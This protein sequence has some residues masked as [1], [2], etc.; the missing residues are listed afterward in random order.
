MTWKKWFFY[1]DQRYALKGSGGTGSIN[2]ASN[3]GAGDGVFKQ[4]ALDDLE[5]KTLTAGANITLTDSANEIEIS[6]TGGGGGAVDSVNGQTGVVVLDA[7]DIS[8]AA[9][10]NKFATAAELA[11]IALNTADRHVAVSVT[12]SPEIDFT[13][14][15]QDITASIVAGSLN[16]SKFDVSVNASLDLADTAL[17]DVVNDTT[18]TL[19]GNLDGGGFNVSSV[20]TINIAGRS[21][22]Y[23]AI[24]NESLV[25]ADTD[26]TYD[27]T[28]VIIPEAFYWGGTHTLTGNGLGILTGALFRA[29]GTI[30]NENGTA[31]TLGPYYTVVGQNTYQAD[32]AAVTQ[33][34]NFNLYSLPTFSGINGGAFTC[35][36]MT[37]F[38]S[39]LY[40]N[41]GATITADYSFKANTPLGTGGTITG[42]A[43]F[44]DS[45]F[46][47]ATNNTA[48]LT[49]TST[50]PSGNWNVYQANGRLNR[51]NGGHIRRTRTVSATTTVSAADDVIHIVGAVAAVT[52]T[53]PAITAALL[54]RVIT[55]KNLSGFNVTVQSAGAN[56]I[57]LLATSVVFGF[58]EAYT[59]QVQSA[60]NWSVIGRVQ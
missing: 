55:F 39:S 54:G 40:I 36:D 13:L 52:I 3:V 23:T 28:N 48:L 6:A 43:S 31:L 44:C 8:D 51:W 59:L 34:A 42:H 26:H 10:A 32:N 60:S 57:D 16:E 25:R 1:G 53:L 41:A 19:G 24:A 2:T 14:T 45:G 30:K 58:A 18:P 27:Y 33:S 5:F 7:D 21:T 46:T 17:Q 4:K 35:T 22:D 56:T 11:D 47:T 15:G 37:H 20:Q 29:T 50:I 38:A 12:D 9:T 49:G